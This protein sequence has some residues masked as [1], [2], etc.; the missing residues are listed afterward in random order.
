[1]KLCSKCQVNKPVTDFSKD[2]HA[3]DGLAY[4]CKP[5]ASAGSRKSY[6]TRKQNKDW[7]SNYRQG[8]K[9]KYKER[10][11]KAVQLL[12]GKCNDCGGSFPNC[13]FDFHHLDESVKDMNPSKALT[14]NEETM[15]EELSKCV[16]LCANCHRIR[17]WHFEGGTQ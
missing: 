15:L 11:D 8:Y 7:Y 4:Y 3:K 14:L 17:H 5:C 10:K 13:V 1:M 9:L 12:G 6:S 16:L 2:K